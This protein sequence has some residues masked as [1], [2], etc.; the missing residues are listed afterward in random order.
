MHVC[1]YIM[2]RV[3]THVC[4]YIMHRGEWH[5][6]LMIFTFTHANCNLATVPIHMASALC[7]HSTTMPLELSWLPGNCC[8]CTN[9]YTFTH[10]STYVYMYA[11]IHTYTASHAKSQTHITFRHVQRGVCYTQL[12]LP[13]MTKQSQCRWTGTHATP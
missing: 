4:V 10:K 12:I 1:V 5:P 8:M 2:H 7:L 11:K 9:T 3:S 13:I 6:P